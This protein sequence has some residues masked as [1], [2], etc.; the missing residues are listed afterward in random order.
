MGM[1]QCQE[2]KKKP[3]GQKDWRHLSAFCVSEESEGVLSSGEEANTRARA[4]KFKHCPEMVTCIGRKEVSGT[5]R[6]AEVR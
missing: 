5:K 3:R 4:G 2:L 6:W 1:R